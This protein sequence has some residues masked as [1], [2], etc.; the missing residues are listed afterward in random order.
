MNKLRQLTSTDIDNYYKGNKNFGGWFNKNQLPRIK[1]KF[2]MVNMEDSG[3]GGTHWVM[4]YNRKPMCIYYDSF[5][6]HP[7]PDI[8]KFMKGSGKKSVMSDIQIQNIKSQA[9][10]YY[11]LMVIDMLEEGIPF[12]DILLDE[13]SFDTLDNEKLVNKETDFKFG[14][15]EE[16]MGEGIYGDGILRAVRNR[17]KKVIKGTKSRIRGFIEGARTNAPPSVRKWLRRDGDKNVVHM[18]VCRTPV[19]QTVQKAL[20][21]VSLGAWSRAKKRLDYDD[22]YHLYLFV[23]YDDGTTY[24]IEKNEV[25]T[26]FKTKHIVGDCKPVNRI[27]GRKIKVKDLIENSVRHNP[28][29]FWLYASRTNNC[30]V[31]VKSILDSNG[32]NTPEL[33]DFIKQDAIK[34]FER[35]PA[36]VEIIANLT[37]DLG[38]RANILLEGR[39]H[40]DRD[41]DCKL[42]QDWKK[43]Y[44]D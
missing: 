1:N 32:L 39:G 16:I 40:S 43:N 2:Y 22:M 3:G 13:F 20:D 37:T 36:Y 10:G 7:P 6:L 12:T 30:Q 14:K 28:L 8:E 35:L 33:N 18:I 38:A 44:I 19:I 41:W 5:G 26:V 42:Y 34:L 17:I 31:F 27:R 23:T 4:V 21:I 11:C 15:E 9:C 25:V 29:T 24:R